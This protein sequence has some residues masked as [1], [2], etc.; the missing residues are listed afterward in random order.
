MRS[1]LRNRTF[2]FPSQYLE[3]AT[4]RASNVVDSGYFSTS[5]YTSIIRMGIALCQVIKSSFIF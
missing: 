4:L 3:N 2:P 1:C 5:S